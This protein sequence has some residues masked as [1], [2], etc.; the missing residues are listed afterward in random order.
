MNIGISNEVEAAE[1]IEKKAKIVAFCFSVLFGFPL[2]YGASFFCRAFG[3]AGA[4]N[5][6]GS[7]S[8]SSG[9]DGDYGDGE[10]AEDRGA[11]VAHMVLLIPLT[12]FFPSP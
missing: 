9:T 8:G 11:I 5:G 4:R 7:G 12:C 6:R 3:P 1:G 10:V 2:M